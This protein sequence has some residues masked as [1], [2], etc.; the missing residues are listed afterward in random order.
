M[1]FSLLGFHLSISYHIC[2]LLSLLLSIP[3]LIADKGNGKRKENDNQPIISKSLDWLV[4][5]LSISFISSFP[6][7]PIQMWETIVETSLAKYVELLLAADRGNTRLGWLFLLMTG[8]PYGLG[9]VWH[10]FST[11]SVAVQHPVACLASST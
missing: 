10:I 7:Q 5:S 11:L 3:K 9:K 8:F 2:F 4:S 6:H 1:I